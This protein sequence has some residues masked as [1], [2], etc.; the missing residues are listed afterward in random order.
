MSITQSKS[1]TAVKPTQEPNSTGYENFGPNDSTTFDDRDVPSY[2]S[3]YGLY[4]GDYK[5]EQSSATT[6]QPSTV[7]EARDRAKNLSPLVKK[8]EM[9]KPYD[10]FLQYYVGE[11]SVAEAEKLCTKM[12]SFRFYH[13]V[14][15]DYI[16]DMDRLVE[17]ISI[18]L[19]YR[20]QNGLA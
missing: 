19:V 10:R 12:G 16:D 7:R 5:R 15:I 4:A 14:S 6:A 18:Y 13:R 9:E 1:K 2:E 3:V 20:A 8:Y 17:G 11:E